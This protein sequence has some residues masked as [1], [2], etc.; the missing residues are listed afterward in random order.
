M[1]ISRV[2]II[3]E[4]SQVLA[5]ALTIAIRYSVVRRQ[6]N[7]VDGDVRERKLLD[8]QTQLHKLGPLL[9][10]CAS[11]VSVAKRLVPL[12]WELRD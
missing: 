2:G 7:S 10:I 3:G 9:A 5:R 1:L 12:Y 8:Y 4:M 6:F 11:F